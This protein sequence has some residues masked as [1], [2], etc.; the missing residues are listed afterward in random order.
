[1]ILLPKKFRFWQK[2]N[3]PRTN[4]EYGAAKELLN[5]VLSDPQ[6]EKFG[7]DS[8][9]SARLKD[10]ILT[11]VGETLSGEDKIQS[12]RNAHGNLVCSVAEFGVLVVEPENAMPPLI[13]GELRGEI[14]RLIELDQD[15]GK[16]FNELPDKATTLEEMIGV[17]TFHTFTKNIWLKSYEAVRI[18]LGD[19][20]NDSQRDWS[21]PFL[22]SQQIFTEWHYR[23]T[24]DLPSNIPAGPEDDH[25]GPG[26]Y[27]AILHSRWPQIIA[28]GHKDPRAVWEQEWV[29]TF[30]YSSPYHGKDI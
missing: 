12:V 30:G 16:F 26:F 3:S 21:R 14:P 5:L 13:S 29:K 2:E 28:E 24:L 9:T 11:S 4:E 19:C 27:K 22:L 20:F 18:A 7:V 23:R 15:L 1:M 17:I 25:M 6:I 10:Q 8:S